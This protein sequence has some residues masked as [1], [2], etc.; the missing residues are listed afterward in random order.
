MMVNICVLCVS[1]HNKYL[2]KPFKRLIFTDPIR[3]NVHIFYI[4]ILVI[5]IICM[6]SAYIIG[7]KHPVQILSIK[8]QH[9]IVQIF[10]D[11]T[12]INL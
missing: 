1:C 7:F 3:K 2:I 8:E 9:I 11:V 5:L 4:Q 6:E 10:D 12:V